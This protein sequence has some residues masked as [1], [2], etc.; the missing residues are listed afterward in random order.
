MLRVSVALATLLLTLVLKLLVGPYLSGMVQGSSHKGLNMLKDIL[1]SP[2]QWL[3]RAVWYPGGCKH[4][5]NP[6]SGSIK[7]NIRR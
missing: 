2:S 4:G 1:S 5:L 7:G 3:S 6:G